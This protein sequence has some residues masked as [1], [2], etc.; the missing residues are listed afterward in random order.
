MRFLLLSKVFPEQ[1]LKIFYLPQKRHEP[2]SGSFSQPAQN[3]SNSTLKLFR[4]YI[5]IVPTVHTNHST[6]RS[7]R[8][9]RIVYYIQ[10]EFSMK[11]MR[12]RAL[13]DV[14][15]GKGRRKIKPGWFRFSKAAW[16]LF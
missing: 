1:S 14:P 3:N 11:G 8:F 12:G 5:R 9:G 15:A 7:E 6:K 4:Q 10:K 16:F 2:L 13:R